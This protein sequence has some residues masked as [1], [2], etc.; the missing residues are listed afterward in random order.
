M[1]N[2]RFLLCRHVHM[3]VRQSNRVGL[4]LYLQADVLLCMNRSKRWLMRKLVQV[5]QLGQP[6]QR[7]LGLI[8]DIFRDFNEII[9]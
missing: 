7:R 6:R 4:G 1:S 9:I 2:G 8:A 5:R 3:C